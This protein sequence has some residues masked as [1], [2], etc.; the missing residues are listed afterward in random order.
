MSSTLQSTFFISVDIILK[1]KS[2]ESNIVT[3]SYTSFIEYNYNDKITNLGI[4]NNNKVNIENKNISKKDI[5][6]ASLN[7]KEL[8][9]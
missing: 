6:S 3:I 8:F 5:Y 7:L 1:S 4:L 9:K 2:N